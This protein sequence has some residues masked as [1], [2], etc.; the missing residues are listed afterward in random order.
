MEISGPQGIEGFD[1]IMWVKLKDRIRT[2][3]RKWKL[4]SQQAET[5]LMGVFQMFYKNYL[6]FVWSKNLQNKPKTV[7]VKGHPLSSS[8]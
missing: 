8:G 7:I 3:D 2:V 6:F 1:G 4:I 5:F